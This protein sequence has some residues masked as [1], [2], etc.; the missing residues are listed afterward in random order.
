[1]TTCAEQKNLKTGENVSTYINT[2]ITEHDRDVNQTE[3]IAN[4][5]K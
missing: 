4:M 5:L 3:V 2:D 1:M